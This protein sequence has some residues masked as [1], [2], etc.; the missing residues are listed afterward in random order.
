[1]EGGPAPDGTFRW[2]MPSVRTYTTELTGY[3]V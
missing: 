3:L 1:M 2:T